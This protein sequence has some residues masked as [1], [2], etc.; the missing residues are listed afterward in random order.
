MTPDGKD[1]LPSKLYYDIFTGILTQVIFAYTVAPFILLTFSD[2]MKVWGRVYF[3]ALIG[4]ALSF[5]VFSRSLPVRKQLMQMQAQ[6]TGTTSSAGGAD[7][8]TK[9]IEEV[10]REEARRKRTGNEGLQRAPTLGLP[11]DP[12]ADIG[13]V[14]AEVKKEIEERKRRGSML[15]GFD[16]KKVV[17]EKLN[18]FSK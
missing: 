13:E 14:V 5:G 10:A 3:Y 2:T 1:P 6:R 7:I 8:D 16:V 4:V 18:Q 12:E 9:R 15:Q 11:E 17:N